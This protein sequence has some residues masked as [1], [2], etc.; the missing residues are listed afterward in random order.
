MTKK[1]PKRGWLRYWPRLIF[2]IPLILV[3]WVPSYNRIEPE[4]SG[5]PFFYWYQLAL[6]LLGA[7]LVLVVY[8]IE[9]I[10]RRA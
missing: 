3:L 2:A 5:I 8:A 9:T 7:A 10:L 1:T 6:I 4:L